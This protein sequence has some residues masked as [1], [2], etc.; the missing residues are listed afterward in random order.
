MDD[1]DQGFSSFAELIGLTRSLDVALAA[2]HNVDFD[3]TTAVCGNVD[4]TVTAWSSL[5]PASKKGIMRLDGSFDELLFK[6]NAIILTCAFLLCF[7]HVVGFFS[8]P[9]RA[10][11]KYMYN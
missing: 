6:A 9:P 1:E 4:A 5:L 7:P 2:R 11:T 10:F 8:A 3:T